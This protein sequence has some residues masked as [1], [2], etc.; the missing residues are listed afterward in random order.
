MNIFKGVWQNCHIWAWQALSHLFAEH[1]GLE[2][3]LRL[4]DCQDCCVCVCEDL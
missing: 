3:R 4:E 1:H 2:A